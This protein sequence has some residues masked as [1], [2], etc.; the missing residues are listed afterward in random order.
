MDFAGAGWLEWDSWIYKQ[1]VVVRDLKLLLFRE[2]RETKPEYGKTG[3]AG[4]EILLFV[5]ISLGKDQNRKKGK[6]EN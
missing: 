1:L 3:V 2:T 4:T 5:F 6:R